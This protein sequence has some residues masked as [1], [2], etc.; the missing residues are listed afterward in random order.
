MNTLSRVCLALVLT[1]VLFLP[2][3]FLYPFLVAPSTTPA[4]IP[5]TRTPPAPVTV[6]APTPK[7]TLSPTP[8]VNPTPAPTPTKILTAPTSSGSYLDQEKPSATGALERRYDWKYGRGTYWMTLSIPEAL[9]QRFKALPRPPTRN[10]SVYVTH[11]DN[12]LTV[13]AVVSILKKVAADNK[14]NEYQTVELATSFVQSLPYTVDSVSSGF[15]EY[16]RY[17]VE[18]LADNGGDCEDTAIL[19]AGIL[20]GMGYATVLIIYPGKHC[21]LGV[22]G[23]EGVYGTYY[24]Y[25]GR[26]YY[27]VE[28]TNSGWAIGQIPPDYKGLSANIFP[29][30]PVPVLTHAWKTSGVGSR[31]ELEVTVTN[32]GSAGAGQVTVLGGFDAGNSRL[33]NSQRSAAFSLAP[34]QSYRVNMVL[35]APVD[36]HTRLRVQ[37]SLDGQGVDE[38]FS[39]WID[40]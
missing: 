32:L 10:Y 31:V 12:E 25:E 3:C 19:L 22:A 38:S 39:K 13:D 20:R 2:G 40:T 35:Q 24:T 26:R 7:P 5:S 34:G 28:T 17:P 30:K 18:T 27:Y 21:A 36:V 9:Y 33:W 11:P 1:A 16:P 6:P 15:D 8:T 29:M 37:V 23:G 14:L 4:T